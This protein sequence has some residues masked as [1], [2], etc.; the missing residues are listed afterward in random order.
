[1]GWAWS[2]SRNFTS[3]WRGLVAETDGRVDQHPIAFCPIDQLHVCEGG[4]GNRD[5]SAIERPE[6]GRAH[7]DGFDGA[8]F[9]S[10]IAEI[11]DPHGL[12]QIEHN[13]ADQVFEG[14]ANRKRDG[15]T[16]NTQT[17]YHAVKR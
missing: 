16:A 17:G 1:L 9:V 5:H 4:V 11:A 14:R 8:G 2:I 7:A 10:K 3:T 6:L 12:V 13:A 15:Q